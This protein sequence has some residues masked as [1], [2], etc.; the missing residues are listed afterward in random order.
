MK[1]SL[2]VLFTLCALLS[3][4]VYRPLYS[5]IKTVWIKSLIESTNEFPQYYYSLASDKKVL[6]LKKKK[7]YKKT[8]M[9]QQIKQKLPAHQIL[10]D[11]NYFLFYYLSKNTYDT[12]TV[13]NFLKLQSLELPPIFRSVAG[14]SQKT[15]KLIEHIAHSH[16]K[17]KT[18][19]AFFW[20]FLL[21]HSSQFQQ[22][23][24]DK[25]EDWAELCLRTAPRQSEFYYYSL[26]HLLSLDRRK[27]KAEEVQSLLRHPLSMQPSQSDFRKKLIE[28][29]RNAARTQ[30]EKTIVS[31]PDKSRNK[32]GSENKREA[33]VKAAQALIGKSWSA[34]DPFNGKSFNFDCSGMVRRVYWENGIDLFEGI[35]YNK[36]RGKN[37][38]YILYH[39]Q[40]S[41]GELTQKNPRPGDLVYF[42]NTYDRNRNGRWDDKLTHVGIVT[43]V[44]RDGTVHYIH[45]SSKGVVLFKMNLEKKVYK[46]AEGKVVNHFLRRKRNSDPRGKCYLSACFFVGYGQASFN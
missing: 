5:G 23:N 29:Q 35:D 7:A 42:D 32:V 45:H 13:D 38:V 1:T 19:P 41:K 4:G 2:T 18:E 24:Q 44:D 9:V 17:K 40:A 14:D 25:L 43:Q 36:Y 8:V 20:S 30:S 11:Q 15:A 33:I 46:D 34:K 39:H 3:A 37:G 21:F 28:K 22:S 16:L 10:Y 6:Q 31:Q 12:S 26:K 27:A